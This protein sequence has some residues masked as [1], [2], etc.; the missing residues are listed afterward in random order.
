MHAIIAYNSLICTAQT[1]KNGAN[2]QQK[3]W[4]NFLDKLDWDKL[5]NKPKEDPLRAFSALS[6]YIVNKG[7]K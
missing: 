3:H 2:K 4:K 5:T 6:K 1:D 7:V